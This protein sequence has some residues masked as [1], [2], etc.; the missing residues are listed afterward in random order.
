MTIAFLAAVGS[1]YGSLD[2]RSPIG[3]NTVSPV[4]AKP[5]LPEK[6]IPGFGVED[7]RLARITCGNL[8]R[9]I[10]QVQLGGPQWSEMRRLSITLLGQGFPVWEPYLEVAT[11]FGKLLEIVSGAEKAMSG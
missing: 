1:R 3:S 5:I 2:S 6:T 8:M 11:L 9:L 10:S 7:Y 4:S